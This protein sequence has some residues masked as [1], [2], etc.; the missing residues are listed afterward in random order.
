MTKKKFR[1]IKSFF[2]FIFIMVSSSVSCAQ[3]ISLDTFDLGLS[4]FAKVNLIHAAVRD[5]KG[6]YWL[7]TEVGLYRYDGRQVIKIHSDKAMPLYN[8]PVSRLQ[9]KGDNIWVGTTSG[10]YYINLDTY[11]IHSIEQMKQL[12][13][14]N[15]SVEGDDIVVTSNKSGAFRLSGRS[16]QYV[17]DEDFLQR[18]QDE[19]VI[20]NKDAAI[21]DDGN[22]WLSHSAGLYLYNT[23]TRAMTNAVDGSHRYPGDLK[24]IATE[25]IASVKRQSSNLI[26]VSDKSYF[27][28]DKDYHL[29]EK[30]DLPCSGDPGCS[31]L[32]LQADSHG[33][34]WGRLY[35]TS[36]AKVDRHSQSIQVVDNVKSLYLSDIS[37]DDNDELLFF[38]LNTLGGAR[39]EQALYELI[40]LKDKDSSLTGFMPTSYQQSENGNI[41]LNIDDRL[42]ELNPLSKNFNQ[43]SLGHSPYSFYI[44]SDKVIWSHD[45]E[46]TKIISF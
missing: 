9:I 8:L 17:L 15:I 18:Q 27:L 1:I 4:D 41:W 13:V 10:L 40:D 38:G 42:L 5:E 21:M 24:A 23:N 28:F 14:W 43:Y 12:Y 33:T 32:K 19:K 2:R 6:F 11:K 26:V 3:S 44:D 7:G 37:I 39:V 29:V 22:V 20:F 46:S 36:I 35:L 31:F 16:K 34:I 30:I 25:S 45:S